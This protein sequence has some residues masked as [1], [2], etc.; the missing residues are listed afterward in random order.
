MTPEE[1]LTRILSLERRV[2]HSFAC[3]LDGNMPHCAY[4][5]AIERVVGDVPDPADLGRWRITEIDS[6]GLPSLERA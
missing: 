2:E 6:E 1:R 5:T 4:H 3:R